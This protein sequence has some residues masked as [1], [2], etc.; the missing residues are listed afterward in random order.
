MYEVNVTNLSGKR[1]CSA[2]FQANTS[3]DRA[4]R[5]S[6]NNREM[7]FRLPVL[8]NRLDGP[9]QSTKLGSCEDVSLRPASRLHKC[10]S[11]V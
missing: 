11:A 8:E 6:K 5:R 1:I 10:L 3:L 9:S 7:C 2:N 4:A